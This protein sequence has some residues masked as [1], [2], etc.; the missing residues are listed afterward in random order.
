MRDQVTD[1]IDLDHTTCQLQLFDYLKNEIKAKSRPTEF[2]H[3][4]ANRLFD[5]LD[6]K[7]F[8]SA[9]VEL[10]Y[11]TLQNKR[12]TRPST[13][14]QRK[15]PT[16]SNTTTNKSAS[17]FDTDNRQ[18]SNLHPSSLMDECELFDEYEERLFRRISEINN[19]ED[20]DV[21]GVESVWDFLNRKDGGREKSSHEL[22]EMSFDGMTPKRIRD[23]QFVFIDEETCIGCTQVHN[24][25]SFI[26]G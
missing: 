19:N 3:D 5:M 13:A 14:Q 4:I 24:P 8:T 25:L 16:T 18:G 17:S 9:N 26:F 10:C 2:V 7:H 11:Q 22:V 12:K 6:D 1:P 23:G 21:T 20:D 15:T